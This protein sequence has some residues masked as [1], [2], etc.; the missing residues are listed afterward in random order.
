[1]NSQLYNLP[2]GSFLVYPSPGKSEEHARYKKAVLSI[3]E[4]RVRPEGERWPEYAAKRLVQLLPES[5]LEHFFDGDPCLVPLPRSGLSAKDSVWPAK[6]ISESLVHHGLGAR[7]ECAIERRTAVHKSAGSENRPSPRDHYSSFRAV[8]VKA[9]RI[10]LVDDVVTRGSTA[11]G[12]AWRLL[13][14]MPVAQVK[15]FAVA[16]T[17]RDHEV[18]GSIDI[19]LGTIE[20]QSPNYLLRSP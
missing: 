4:D 20:L 8:P 1:M 14:V 13:E 17:M 12:A 16:R 10:I 9:E 11:L 19:V 5:P 15:L 6:R 3:K 7:V 18:R 2:F